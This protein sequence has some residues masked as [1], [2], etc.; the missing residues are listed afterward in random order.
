MTIFEFWVPSNR[1]ASYVAT[2]K[3]TCISNSNYMLTKG[4]KIRKLSE[5][6]HKLLPDKRQNLISH[7]GA[8]PNFHL[9]ILQCKILKVAL[10]IS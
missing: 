7:D 5:A 2:L 8:S 6:K 3:S 10:R 1:L 4:N 9:I